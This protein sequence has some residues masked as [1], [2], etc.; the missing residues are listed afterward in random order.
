MSEESLLEDIPYAID[1]TDAYIQA[2]M[3]VAEKYRK[4]IVIEEF[5][6]PRDGFLFSKDT[7]TSARDLYYSHLFDCIQES[8]AEGGLLAGVN[9]WAWGGYASQSPDHIYWQN[10]DDYC[11]DP[12]QEQ[13]G[14]NSVYA[15]DTTVGIIREA[16]SRISGSY[17][18]LN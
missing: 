14:L 17:K 10:G 12:A 16:V 11:G 7:T 6:F 15:G 4:P 13:Q 8:A 9:F 1:Q 18:N 5:G 3:A 2:H